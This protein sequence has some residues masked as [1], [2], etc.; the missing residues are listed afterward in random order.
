MIAIVVDCLD[1]GAFS[2]YID[3]TKCTLG[4]ASSS[5]SASSNDQA[6]EFDGA[7]SI[8]NQISLFGSKGKAYSS[9]ASCLR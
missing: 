8:G 1:T 3:G 7:L 5:G 9:R 6:L 4:T 2:V